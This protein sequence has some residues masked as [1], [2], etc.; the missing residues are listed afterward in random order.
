[1]SNSVST[2]AP[3]VIYTSGFC[4]YCGWARRMLSDKGV[5]YQEIRVDRDPDQRAV[6]ESRSGRT[7]V[8]QI[9]VGDFHVG[10]YDDMAAMDRAG[11][12]DPLLGLSEA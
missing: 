9:F 1:M 5:D 2:L 12:L 8:P 7:S 6:M 4:P 3:V 10:G 11:R